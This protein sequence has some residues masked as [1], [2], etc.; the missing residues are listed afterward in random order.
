MEVIDKHILRCETGAQRKMFDELNQRSKLLRYLFKE[1]NNI[2]FHIL[3]Y[4]LGYCKGT[5]Y[6]EVEY[7]Y[8]LFSMKALKLQD[9][10]A[11]TVVSIKNTLF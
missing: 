6:I 5:A 2:I 9:R 8:Y 10:N 4:F 7:I 3:K 11:G 1:R